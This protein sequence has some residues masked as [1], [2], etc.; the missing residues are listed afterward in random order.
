MSDIT[1]TRKCRECEKI[2][3]LTSE[4]FHKHKGCKGGFN[5]ICKTCVNE[6]DRIKYHIQKTTGKSNEEK[7][8]KDEEAYQRLINEPV[9]KGIG[10]KVETLKFQLGRE[11]KVIIRPSGKGNHGEDREFQGKAIQETAS[12][13]TLKHKIGYCESF[14]KADLLIDDYKV[15]EVLR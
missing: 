12:H 13:V 5:I 8:R 3:P 1:E 11:Y 6:R 15:K 4:Y 7:E 10:D 2:Y 9:D 14:R